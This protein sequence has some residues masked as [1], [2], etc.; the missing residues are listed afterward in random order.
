M[1]K[2]VVS[3]LD[4]TL[5][6]S[7]HALSQQT[8]STVHRIVK[9]GIRF[10]IATG[11]HYQDVKHIANNLGLDL[12]LITSNGARIHNKQGQTIFRQDIP[13]HI[14]QPL[15]E[16]APKDTQ[17]NIYKEDQW[18]ISKPNQALLEFNK[19]SGFNYSITNLFTT[20]HNNVAKVFFVGKHETLLA[21]ENKINH[22]FGDSVNAAFSLP[23]CLEVMAKEVNKGQALQQVLKIKGFTL[24][25]TVAFGDGMNDYEMLSQVGMPVVMANA[26]DRLRQSLARY[27]N[28]LS[29]DEHGVAQKLEEIFP[30]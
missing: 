29:S 20:D 13:E 9:Q 3:D 6:D 16:M 22:L 19:S 21:L 5:L 28:T 4:G 2:V 7:N 11:R 18:L 30:V 24:E 15:L 10:I 8:I 17:L 26:H 14:V 23:D 25:Q 27:E 12:F 1:Y